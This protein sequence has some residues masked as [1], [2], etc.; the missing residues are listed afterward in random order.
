MAKVLNN[1]EDKGG[2]VSDADLESEL[3]SQTELENKTDS[4]SI[5]G[6]NEF[7]DEKKI[8]YEKLTQAGKP[9]RRLNLK[10]KIVITSAILAGLFIISIGAGYIYLN[11]LLS[12]IDKEESK[13]SNDDFGIIDISDISSNPVSQWSDSSGSAS[14][15]TPAYD[16]LANLPYYYKETK[17]ITNIALF[18]VDAVEGTPGRSDTIIILTIDTKSN[19]IKLTS[20]VRDAYVNIP[21]RGMDKI[22]HAYAFGGPTLAIK[23]LN[24]NFHLDIRKY[25]RVNFSSLPQI[26]DKLGGIEINITQAESTKMPGIDSSGVYN[27]TGK[28]ALAFSRIRSID[29]DIERSRRQ[30]DVVEA[31]IKKMFSQPIASYPTTLKEIFPLLRTNMTSN[32][33]FNLGVNTVMNNIR[34]IEKMRYPTNENGKG[35]MIKG[36]YYVVFDR[37]ATLQQIGKYIYLDQK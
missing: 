29:S 21:G 28:Q 6:E 30:R 35:Q 2:K 13:T 7:S 11:H 4:K 36:N 26:I 1:K 24:T 17:G 37:P 16:P 23:T 20:I 3:S 32:E 18:G 15:S 10:R 31:A 12:F 22:N 19:K 27:L 14:S 34:N 5:R 8:N 25:I 33:M 9:K